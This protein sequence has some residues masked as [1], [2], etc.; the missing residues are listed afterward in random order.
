MRS[1]GA[2]E[3]ERTRRL[4]GVR[5]TVTPASTLPTVSETSMM[6][7]CG[8]AGFREG[9]LASLLGALQATHAQVREPWPDAEGQSYAGCAGAEVLGGA[10]G[11]SYGRRARWL[12]SGVWSRGG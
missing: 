11:Q 2:R 6:A 8:W 4:S 3:E 1:T 9:E 7:G 12:L 10:S 5:R